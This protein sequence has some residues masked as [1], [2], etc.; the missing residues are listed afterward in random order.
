MCIGCTTQSFGF[1]T[2]DENALDTSEDKMLYRM[3]MLLEYQGS[4]NPSVE[5][6]NLSFAFLRHRDGFKSGI[7]IDGLVHQST[8]VWWLVSL[9]VELKPSKIMFWASC[10]SQYDAFF[11]I[12]GGL[13]GHLTISFSLLL[14]L[15]PISFLNGW[16]TLEQWYNGIH[17]PWRFNVQALQCSSQM[18]RTQCS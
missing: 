4:L 5:Q 16:N 2:V 12:K 8:L 7:L 3:W 17:R 11:C 14:Q 18:I 9:E 1:T 13:K 10:H 15:Y 6:L